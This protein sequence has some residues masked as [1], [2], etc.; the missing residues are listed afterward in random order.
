MKHRYMVLVLLVV[1][2]AALGSQVAAT[3]FR[4]QLRLE[5]GK[6]YTAYVSSDT[7]TSLSIQGQSLVTRQL[8]EMA[9][10]YDVIAIDASGAAAVEMTF[11]KM[12]VKME[13]PQGNFAWSGSVDQAQLPPPP[14]L[15]GLAAMVGATLT[16][17]LTP[18]GRT[19]ELQ[20]LDALYNRMIE[21]MPLPAEVSREEFRQSLIDQ[22]GDDAMGGA[23]QN[24]SGA[25]P[26]HP[27]NI[28]DSWP[29]N[30]TMSKGV[31]MIIEG[32]YTLE[33]VENGV[34]RLGVT[35]KIRPNPEGSPMKFGEIAVRCDLTG[36]ETGYI[37]MEEGTGWVVRGEITTRFTGQL[38]LE[39]VP[40][41]PAGL[42]G[43]MTTES[44]ILISNSPITN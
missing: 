37:E 29:M 44:T 41:M 5:A 2:M 38:K 36:E 3:E 18:D 20:G 35:A 15:A 11:D 43:P 14:P 16:M 31:P 21:G 24:L 28:G 6:T 30:L 33:S 19:S 25:Y 17:K 1:M 22:F 7:L 4:P 34:A 10:T 12:R 42:M 8:M 23:L 32:S 26:D 13:G 40:E 27:I 39:G 9:Y